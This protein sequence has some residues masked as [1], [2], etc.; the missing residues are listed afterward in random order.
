[1]VG[2]KTED[3]DTFGLFGENRDK[4]GNVIDPNYGD[5]LIILN[6]MVEIY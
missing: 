6:V 4:D 1:M 3:I 2:T 5:V